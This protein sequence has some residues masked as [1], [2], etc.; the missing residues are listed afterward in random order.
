MMFVLD[1]GLKINDLDNSKCLVC[2]KNFK[3]YKLLT[4]NKELSI[5]EV[6]IRTAHTGCFNLRFIP[7]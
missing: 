7:P 3:H 2:N 6:E 1:G 5:Q 4:M